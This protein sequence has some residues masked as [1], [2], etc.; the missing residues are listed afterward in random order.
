MW[1]RTVALVGLLALVQGKITDVEIK[2]DDRNIILIARPFGYA[3]NVPP[4][5]RS[6]VSVPTHAPCSLRRVATH[7]LSR[8]TLF[9][10]RF[11]HAGV[12]EVHLRGDK[13]FLPEDAPPFQ[14][15]Q[16]SKLGFFITTAEAEVRAHRPACASLALC[17]AP[18]VGPR[19]PQACLFTVSLSSH[20]LGAALRQRRD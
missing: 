20:W 1:F 3:P 5:N 4:S 8:N 18:I 13:V 9:T 2:N 14:Q 10:R 15:D 7:A 6:L 17:C 19:A 12:I 11:S 16:K